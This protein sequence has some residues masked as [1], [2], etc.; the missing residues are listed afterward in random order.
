MKLGMIALYAEGLNT[1]MGILLSC[2]TSD[3]E[4][5]QVRAARYA[6]ASVVEQ[7][8]EEPALPPVPSLQPPHQ[9]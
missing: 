8:Q 6:R 3:A 1:R 5:E 9:P 7:E 4:Q 2:T